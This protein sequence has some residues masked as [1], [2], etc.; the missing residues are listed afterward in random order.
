M[1]LDTSTLRGVAAVQR[2]DGTVFISDTDP[3]VRHGR[4]LVPTLKTL[5]TE[6]ELAPSDLDFIAV[7]LGPGSFTGLRIGVTAAK[8]LAYAIQRP[9]IGLDSLDLIARNAAPE[10]LNVVV[11]VDAQRSQWYAA[12]FG[13][14]HSGG[15]LAR[16]E[17][18]RTVDA[19][20]FLEGLPEGTLVL[21]PALDRDGVCFPP[22]AC[23]GPLERNHPQGRHLL[24]ASREAIKAGRHDDPWF[25]EP[26]Y[27]RRSAAEEKRPLRE[28]EAGHL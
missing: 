19:S 18:T 10:V 12:R 15:P 26:L 17:P 11:V 1:A 13:R 22:S 23:R 3:T 9:L 6:A 16:L 25:L 24:T 28:H 8:T 5:M 7:G 4:V 2:S 20:A 14:T 27:I 21:G